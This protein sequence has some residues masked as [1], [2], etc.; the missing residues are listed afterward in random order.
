[1]FTAEYQDAD[2]KKRYCPLLIEQKP[3]GGKRIVAYLFGRIKDVPAYIDLVELLLAAEPNDDFVLLIDSPGGY[4][5]GGSIIASAVDMSQANVITKCVG[6][7]ASAGALILNSAKKENIGIDTGCRVMYHMSSHVDSG[8][9]LGIRDR[10]ND[11]VR[12]V[13]D[14]LL[15]K[16]V[17]DGTLT[18]EEMNELLEN[19]SK[20]FFLTQT[21][22]DR[23]L[24]GIY[25]KPEGAN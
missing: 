4:I 15:A 25:N 5:S 10:A 7:C 14:V 23:R 24:K 22:F 9:S 20:E 16:A 12:Y 19:Q 11:Q 21:E 8:N 6:L 2:K 13:K 1:M 18:Q 3:D 17:E